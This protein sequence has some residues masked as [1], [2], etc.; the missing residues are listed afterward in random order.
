[1]NNTVEIFRGCAAIGFNKLPKLVPEL[2]SRSPYS[3]L[4]QPQDMHLRQ[5]SMK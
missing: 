4:F 3:H 5:P 2:H 1:L